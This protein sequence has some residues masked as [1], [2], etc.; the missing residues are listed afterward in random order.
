[1]KQQH[2]TE[3]RLPRGRTPLSTIYE[4]RAV[5]PATFRVRCPLHCATLARHRGDLTRLIIGRTSPCCVTAP[6]LSRR[7][8]FVGLPVSSFGRRDE[9]ALQH[10]FKVGRVSPMAET[11][12]R[13]RKLCSSIWTPP[14]ESARVST[15][16]RSWAP[17][18]PG[19][20]PKS[21]RPPRA[22]RHASFNNQ[23]NSGDPQK[24][25]YNRTQ[26]HRA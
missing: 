16:M 1:L 9:G 20:R 22:A 11:I 18:W 25:D 8:P 23:W 24:R 5:E 2:R 14:P 13:L 6:S 19:G 3:K 26:V 17:G 15:A 7:P 4:V 10:L 21:S 12:G